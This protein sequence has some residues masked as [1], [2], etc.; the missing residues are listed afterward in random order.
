MV[1]DAPLPG[2][3][4]WQSEY[5]Q[6]IETICRNFAVTPTDIARRIGASP[7]TITRQI[8]PGWTRRPQLDIL[9]R[10][11]QSY[12]QAIPASLIGTSIVT[13]GFAEPDVQ[14]LIRE[15][16]DARDLNLSD[17]IVRTAVLAA[18]GCNVGDVLTFDARI[19]PVAE[20]VVI[21]QVYKFGQP[22]AETVMRYYLPPFLIAA[23]IGRPTI[24]PIVEDPQNE[25]V[26]IMGTMVRR[27][28]ERKS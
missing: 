19:K 21:A 17:W 18:I 20:D 22:G 14:P 25:R 28:Y 1:M 4:E 23:Q 27:A 9:R 8:K 24:A 10:I 2:H 3:E 12:G 26:V 15:H 13:H 5:R 6:W 16:D 7:S 11:A